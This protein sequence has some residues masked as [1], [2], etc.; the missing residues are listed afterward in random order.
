M[1]PS[2]R[3][4]QSKGRSSVFVFIGARIRFDFGVFLALFCLAGMARADWVAFNDHV[5]GTSGTQT[6]INTTTNN[7]R[8]QS[9]GFL[10]NIANGSNLPVVLSITRNGSGV[11]FGNGGSSPVVGTPLS[12]FNGYVYFGTGTD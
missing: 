1:L 9:S 6:H 10:K 4:Q 2:G 3:F 11:T 12:Q 5:P 7:I 8:L